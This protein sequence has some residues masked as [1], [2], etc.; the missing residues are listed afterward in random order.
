MV[1]TFC[2]LDIYFYFAFQA[3][4]AELVDALDLGSSAIGVGVQVPSPALI[5][6]WRGC[7]HN[8]VNFFLT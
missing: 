3:G 1:K 5:I 4:V 8:F 2:D 7:I 6:S